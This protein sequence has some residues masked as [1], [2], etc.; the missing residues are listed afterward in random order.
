M[1]IGAYAFSG[2]RGLTSM[3]LPSNLT[4]IGN[5]AFRGCSGLTSMTFPTGLTEIGNSAFY[6]CSGLISLILPSE[7]TTIGNDSFSNCSNLK[8]IYAYMLTPLII[9]KGVFDDVVKETATLYVP[10]NSYTGYWL[11]DGW[12]DFKNIKTFD[13]TPVESVLTTDKASE[14]SRY[15]VYGQRQGKSIKGLNIVKMSDGSVKK[16]MEQ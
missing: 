1:E 6:S 5:Y 12:G 11:S 3:T 4:K 14:L 9:E 8:S 15:N 10:V 13:P 7:L 2:C 16:I